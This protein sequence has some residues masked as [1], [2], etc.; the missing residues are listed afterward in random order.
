MITVIGYNL[1]V[2]E[3]NK[4]EIDD[5]NDAAFIIG[6]LLFIGGFTYLVCAF[7]NMLDYS[8]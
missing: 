6:S 5:Q 3:A 4:E 2:K 8:D 1:S 7:V